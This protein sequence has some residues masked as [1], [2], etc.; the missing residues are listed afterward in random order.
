MTASKFRPIYTLEINRLSTSVEAFGDMEALCV[1]LPFEIHQSVEVVAAGQAHLLRIRLAKEYGFG[2]AEVIAA[3]H[4]ELPPLHAA[5]FDPAT[6]RLREQYATPS[7]LRDILYIDGIKVS[8]AHRGQELGL[9]TLER[10]RDMFGEGCAVM[11]LRAVPLAPYDYHQPDGLD[12]DPGL[13][14]RLDSKVYAA[15]FKLKGEDAKAK[16]RSHFE[17]VGFKRVGT[18]DFMVFDMLESRP[19]SQ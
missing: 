19:A 18:T 5:L 9:M 15:P 1:H 4:E 2:A 12:N 11:V 16:L 13:V 17:K 8:T 14:D 6:D 3:C 10:L 7:I